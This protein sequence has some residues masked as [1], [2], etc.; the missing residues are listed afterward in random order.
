[1]KKFTLAL[2]ALLAFSFSLKA[3]QYVSTQPS[4]RNVIIEEFTGRNCGYCPDGH[5]IAN[6]IMA[7]HPGRAWAVNIHAGG[8]SPTS[9]P[10]LNTTDG[11]AINNGFGISAYPNGVINRTTGSG[12][13]RSQ[14]TSMSETQLAEAAEVNLAGV[15][16]ID[17]A[18]RIASITVEV[19]YTANSNESTN[20]L[21]VVMLQDSILGS[22]S[23]GSTYNPQQMIGGQ[24][25]HM[26]TLRDVITP[27]WGETVSPTTAGSLVT[28]TYTYEIPESIGS[29]NGVEV[30]INN[31]TFMAW[32]TEKY[33]GTPTRPILNA[34]ELLTTQGSSDYFRVTTS[35]NPTA[36]GNTTGTGWYEPGSSCTVTATAN[37]G[38]TFVNWTENGTQVSTNANY[39]F[40]VNGNRNLVANFQQV[41]YTITTSS[42]PANGG[43]TSGGGSFAQGA[44]CT[45]H[46]TANNGYTFVNWTEN[47]TQVSTSA[48][49]TFTVNGNR[50][51]VANFSQQT[52]TISTSSNPTAGGAT[53]G[54]GT[55]TYGESCTVTATAN[56][57]YTFE[58]W[59]QGSTQ[60]STDASYTFTVTGNRNLVAHFVAETYTVT[61]EASD[62]TMGTVS[63]GGN[64]TAGQTCGVAAHANDGFVFLNW[65]DNGTVVS[66]NA[67]F[68]FTVTGSCTLVANFASANVTITAT[69][70]PAQ[71]GTVTGAGTYN[72]GE[73][74][75]LEVVPAENY[76]FINWTENGQVVS[77]E[78]TYTFVAQAS[79]NLVAHLEMDDA[80]GE[81][82]SGLMVYP[83]PAQDKLSIE[84]GSN[85]SSLKVYSMTGAMVY[86]M[87]DCGT[88]TVIRLDDMPKGVYFI[89]L[90][91]NGAVETMRFVKE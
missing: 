14:W 4:N 89:Q 55:Y 74:V 12:V 30:D 29:P 2:M 33:Q 54:G 13:S 37:S 38:Y 57:G 58:K 23:G 63:G 20:Y 34:C 87:E 85:I 80:V 18:T 49:Y 82:L 3:Q 59:M 65:T 26:H 16:V 41:N 42:S 10:N 28:K 68:T 67:F 83:N 43:T 73:T 64:F 88:H 71:A 61:V 44:S 17:P 53:T 9:Y 51:L 81:H 35:S 25:V 50:N 32:V 77:E 48:N 62:P 7:A 36:G 86:S 60:V 31:V 27:T 40:T 21:T 39:T 19:Y 84:C 45:V 46:A 52:Y 79:R 11:T 24:Y 69:V 47:G 5:R 78:M 1:M 76:N 8:F 22:Q 6:Q 90:S 72:A 15:A 75:T 66:T 91:S 70:D 56:P